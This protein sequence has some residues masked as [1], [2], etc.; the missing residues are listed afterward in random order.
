MWEYLL[1]DEDQGWHFSRHVG[2]VED[3]LR[4]IKILVKERLMIGS[5]IE[6][7][8]SPRVGSKMPYPE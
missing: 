4:A 8:G 1:S 6:L 2:K 7:N 5:E 3:T